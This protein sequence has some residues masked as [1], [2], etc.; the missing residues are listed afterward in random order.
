L[1]HPRLSLTEFSEKVIKIIEDKNIV[2]IIKL[3]PTFKKGNN[4]QMN[5]FLE[6]DDEI[7]RIIH[8]IFYRQNYR[9]KMRILLKTQLFQY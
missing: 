6:T 2:K 3:I 8:Q 4:F 1:E 9:T 5:K 7:K